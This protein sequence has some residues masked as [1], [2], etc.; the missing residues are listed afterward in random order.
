MQTHIFFGTLL[1]AIYPDKNKNMT[2][3][4]KQ[5]MVFED[6]FKILGQAPVC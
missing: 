4:S 1:S 5:G 3:V 6:T 2:N